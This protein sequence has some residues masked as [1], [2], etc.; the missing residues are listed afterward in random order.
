M[1][2]LLLFFIVVIIWILVYLTSG[3]INR[4]SDSMTIHLKKSVQEVADLLRQ[5]SGELGANVDKVED[6][7]FGKFGS[8]E[9]LAVVLSGE[10]RGLSR[11]IWA[12]HVYVT[13][14]SNGCDVELI[15]LGEGLSAGYSGT[16]YSGR[17]KLA[18]SK[19]R[20]DIIAA[21]L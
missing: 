3:K 12:V 21:R 10:E 4:K 17:I 13:T 8:S 6:D 7:P 5:V 14:A 16:Y 15:A 1:E 11:D 20:R 9:D 2:V 18:S 19:K